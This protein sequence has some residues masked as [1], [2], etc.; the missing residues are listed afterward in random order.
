MFKRIT[1]YLLAFWVFLLPWQTRW[2][3]LDPILQG[4]A[5]EYGRI[6]LYVGDIIF[7]MLMILSGILWYRER[8]RLEIRFWSFVAL[9]SF[10]LW[11]AL[12]IGWAIEKWPAAYLSLRIAQIPLLVA[13][14]CIIRPRIKIITQSLLAAGIIQALLAIMQFG[15]Q[16][17]PGFKW[18]GLASHYAW[19]LGPSV[20]ESEANRWLRAYGSLPH[21][22]ILG[23]LLALATLANIYLISLSQKIKWWLIA[24]LLLISEGLILSF[25]RSAWLGLAF[26]IL[27]LL[28]LSMRQPSVRQRLILCAVIIAIMFVVSAAAEPELFLTRF[29]GAARLESQSL[30]E[31]QGQ[32]SLAIGVI[33]SQP[34]GLGI[35]GYTAWMQTVYPGNSGYFYQPVHNIFLLIWSELGLIG[36]VLFLLLTFL[37]FKENISVTYNDYRA[38]FLAG[39]VAALVISVFDHYFWTS[40]SGI[41]LFGLSVA[42]LIERPRQ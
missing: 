41:L 15:F 13:M 35:A 8:P 9:I 37:I 40:Y 32:V 18:L 16:W 33:K 23:G 5:W 42:V 2:I 22:N 1:T 11:S 4:S 36:I 3:I 10:V 7:I 20:V 26:G 14:F 30:V 38:L 6:S 34:L 31:R 19:E 21:P 24:A 28:I 27:F 12:S 17:S 29:D 39:L 25:S